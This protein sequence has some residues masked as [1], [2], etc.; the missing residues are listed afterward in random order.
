MVNRSHKLVLIGEPHWML[1]RMLKRAG[2]TFEDVLIA[3]RYSSVLAQSGRVIVPM[4]ETALYDT[5][6]ESNIL[7][8]R[9]RIIENPNGGFV[10]PALAP[11]DLLHGFGSHLRN[12]PRYT[13]TWVADVR[14][15]LRIAE[16][17]FTRMPLNYLQDPAPSVFAAWAH[18][19][20]VVAPKYLS[21]DIETPYKINAEDGD[22]DGDYN[23]PIIRISFS[24][25]PGQAVSIPWNDA[26]INDI[27]A[28]LGSDLPKAGWNINAFDIPILEAN[29]FPVNGAIY[30]WMDGWHVF[31]SDLDKGLEFVTSFGTDLKP[32]KHLSDSEPT[33]YS[34]V[35]A[36]AVSRLALYIEENLRAQ[37][38]WDAFIDHSVR[39]MPILREA[40]H[41]G[42]LIDMRLQQELMEELTAKEA[43]LL[44]TAQDVVPDAVKPRK[45][46]KKRPDG[47][48]VLTEEGRAL[49]VTEDG[50]RFEPVK[51]NGKVK[52]CSICGA[53]GVTKTK[54][55]KGGKKNPCAGA[56][57]VEKTGR[58][59]EYAEILDF[60]PN[61]AEQLKTY[62]RFYG[63]PM[64]LDKRDSSKI[65]NDANHIANLAEQYG[66]KHPIYEIVG[67][68]H[69]VSKAKGTYV[70]GF[71]PDQHGLIHTT[72]VNTPSTWRLGSRAVN[73]QNVGKRENNPYAK[74]AR[75]QLIARP[76]HVFVQ[77]DSSSVEAVMLG[78]F[79]HDPNYMEIATK[80]V[81]AWLLCMEMGWPFDAEHIKLAKAHKLYTPLKVANHMCMTGDHEV[82]TKRGWVRFDEYDG[83]EAIATWDAT[84][85]AVAYEQPS[86]VTADPYSGELVSLRGRRLSADVTPNHAFPVHTEAV[87]GY[88]RVEVLDMPRTSRIPTHGVC[89]QGESSIRDVDVRL[90]VAIQADARLA[91]TRIVFH[92]KKERKITRLLELLD[93]AGI[94]PMRTNNPDGTT[95]IRIERSSKTDAALSLL[96]TNR[97]FT[98]RVLDLGL[99][100]RC[101]F[102]EEV[103]HWDG[104][105][106]RKPGTQRAYFSKHRVNAEIV[107]AV[108]HVTGQQALLRQGANGLWVVSFNMRKDAKL[109]CMEQGRIQHEGMV[110]CVTVSTGY[111]VYRHRDRVAISGNSNYGGTA[112][113]LHSLHPKLFPT[114]GDAERVQG[115]IFDLLPTLRA[116]QEGV[117]LEAKEN[118]FLTNPWGHRHFFYDV[119]T[120]KLSGGRVVKGPGGKPLVV[121]G[122]DAKRVVAYKPQSSN[123]CFQRDNILLV[124][125]HADLRS[126]MPRHLTV[127]DSLC[128]DVPQSERLRV[129]RQLYAIFTRPI[130]QMDGLCIGADVEIGDN[131][132][133]LEPVNASD[134]KES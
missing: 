111:F 51:A 18:K 122:H 104:T 96:D 65:S 77:I 74:K 73:L 34:C 1:N 133:H 66:E 69:K 38:Q 100:L 126:W 110:Y 42:T 120:Y 64:G 134:L 45:H 84:T 16:E 124:A 118:G 72:Y 58:V 8:W 129:R 53:E 35:D 36:D 13:W 97:Q 12:P 114:L 62:I 17:G 14:K 24:S 132:G 76:G 115:R 127:H 49:L 19:T 112:R 92:F 101:A 39:L 30:D 85:N 59:T 20:L 102:L 31:Q 33:L 57:I 95:T 81:H 9:G 5:L 3:P 27:R 83:A 98:W 55:L 91:P 117:R 108:S 50:R 80:G 79:M 130:P 103:S 26:Y 40:G 99:E 113:M 15:A 119:M 28:L 22:E 128:L 2:L 52:V 71:K 90:A 7:R 67:E 32:W 25:A 105:A 86:R 75:Y 43:E 78:W 70:V 125:E 63:H 6:R 82:L 87:S 10:V 29:G 54:H 68:A 41:R 94:E 116:Y 121:L 107:Q 37:G 48:Q 109:E 47:E 88:S 56:D 4:G 44:A 21:F 11:S 23:S 131:W 60:N 61:S 89:E 123:G 46:F 93:Y 106:G